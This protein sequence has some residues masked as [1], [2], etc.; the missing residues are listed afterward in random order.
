MLRIASIFFAI[1]LCVLPARADDIAGFDEIVSA[2]I[3]DFVVPRSARLAEAAVAGEAAPARL[4]AA[5]SEETLGAARAAFADPVLAHAAV[6]V[7]RFG[8]VLSDNR[9]ERLNFWPDRKGLGLRQVERTIAA[10][11]TPPVDE[12]RAR[13][14]ALQGLGAL[15]FV[16]FGDGAATLA[17]AD[18]KARCAFGHA[19][20]G[21]LRTTAAEVLADW[22]APD[23]HAGL[24]RN[25]GPDNPLYRTETEVMQALIRATTEELQLLADTK[26]RATIGENPEAARPKRAPFWRSGLTLGVFSEN[27]ASVGALFATGRMALALDKSDSAMPNEIAF[28][29]RQAVEAFGRAEG[30]IETVVADPDGHALVLFTTIPLDDAA[31]I[32][33]GRYGPEIGATPGFNSLDGD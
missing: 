21:A 25:P 4:C 5:P 30:P 28:D 27:A 13:S 6:E 29:I 16:L 15:E 12:L 9:L 23:G 19:I 31:A 3:E 14:V 2:T 33:G 7:V 1:A 10:G 8:P 11:E 32:I 20:A 18:G 17:G 26:I 24:M 22:R